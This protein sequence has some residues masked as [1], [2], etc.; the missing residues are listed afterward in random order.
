MLVEDEPEHAVLLEYHLRRSKKFRIKGKAASLKEALGWASKERFDVVLLDMNLPDSKGAATLRH[1]LDAMP[2]VAVV[3]LTAQWTE[4]LADETLA[5]GAEDYLP[6]T[7]VTT[8]LLERSL[9]FAVERHSLKTALAERNERLARFAS[10]AAHEISWPL[11]HI[12]EFSN[13]L[14]KEYSGVLDEEAQ[15]YLSYLGG[16]SKYMGQLVR[17]LLAHA[18][19]AEAKESKMLFKLPDAVRDA[20]VL[21]KDELQERE[22][23]VECE[24]DEE[25]YGSRERLVLVLRNLIG[26]AIKYRAERLPQVRIGAKREPPLLRVW[27]TDNGRGIAPSQAKAIFD[28]FCRLSFQED[29]QRDRVPGVGLGLTICKEIV[30]AH[31][32]RI[33]VEPVEPQGSRFQ[34][35]LASPSG[36]DG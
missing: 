4:K 7:E 8:S 36:G 24:A 27:V 10:A 14:N 12:E 9:W 31:G 30:E 13:L 1:I 2:G 20:T 25:L 23:T 32:G 3:V 22:A 19:Q 6:K 35:T 28:P 21:L 15:S 18:A 5:M 34:F 33:W 29:G 11:R 16:A 26:N 17:A